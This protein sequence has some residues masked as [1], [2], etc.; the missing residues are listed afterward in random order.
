MQDSLEPPE[1]QLAAMRASHAQSTTV[2]RVY[3]DAT[4]VRLEVCL[5][6]FKTLRS[7]N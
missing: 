4:K 2:P 6:A 7:A 3:T 5:K 1:K